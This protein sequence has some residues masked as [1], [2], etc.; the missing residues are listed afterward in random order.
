MELTRAG[1]EKAPSVRGS[2]R[3]VCMAFLQPI[4]CLTLYTLRSNNFNSHLLPLHISY[5]SSGEKLLKYQA[6][7]SC[8][9]LSLILVTTLFYKVL[10]LQGE[11]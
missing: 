1:L 7:S 10:V 9:I 4:L 2:A 5:R 3:L 6:N 11:I 8:M